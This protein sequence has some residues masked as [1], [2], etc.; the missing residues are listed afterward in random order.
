VGFVKLMIERIRLGVTYLS[1]NAS[2]ACS[3]VMRLATMTM[4][5]SYFMRLWP[6]VS[7]SVSTRTA[8]GGAGIV[9]LL[10]HQSHPSFAGS[11][12]PRPPLLRPRAAGY[13]AS[14]TTCGQNVPGATCGLTE[15]R[16]CVGGKSSSI[17]VESSRPPSSRMTSG[18]FTTLV[19][20]LA[21]VGARN[22]CGL[23]RQHFAP[24][25]SWAGFQ[26]PPPAPLWNS[27]WR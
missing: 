13:H 25:G 22:G 14:I 12:P 18:R 16:A 27:S 1:C 15:P 10:H 24:P 23:R 3:P 2:A 7:P 26:R 6:G 20:V 19:F 8:L 11:S 4:V 5:P 17:C 9:T 21:A